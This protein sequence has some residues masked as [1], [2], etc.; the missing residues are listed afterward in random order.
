MRA[1]PPFRAVETWGRRLTS[2]VIGLP[3]TLTEF[4][5]GAENFRRVTQR[6]LDAT[7]GLEQLNEFRGGVGEMRQRVDE[8][9]RAMREQMGSAPGGERMADALGDLNSTLAAV[10]RLNPFWSSGQ[11]RPPP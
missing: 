1:P 2:E 6:L 5:E 3:D 8:A 11:R 7:A 9:A 4:R 10:A